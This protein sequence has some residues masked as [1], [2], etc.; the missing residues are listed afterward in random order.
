MCR[1]EEKKER[2]EK[3]MGKPELLEKRPM[4]LVEVKLLLQK[5]KKDVGELNFRAQR[6]EEYL[7][8]VG[9]LKKKDAEA[10][11][12]ALLELNIPRFK[13]AYAVKLVDVLPK[14]AKEVKLVLQGYPLTVSNDHLEAIAKTI[15]AALPEKKSAK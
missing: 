7:N 15:R 14:T 12:K 11:K 2:V 4:L 8:A 5:I 10:L 3:Q 1:E 13:E 9:P 6:T